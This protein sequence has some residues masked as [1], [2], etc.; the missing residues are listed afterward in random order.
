M[1]VPDMRTREARAAQL[2][3]QRKG[4]GGYKPYG[5]VPIMGQPVWYYY[6]NLPEG[7]LELEVEW[8][9]GDWYWHVTA[10]QMTDKNNEKAPMDE[11]HHSR[12][13]YLVAS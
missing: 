6:Y 10:F 13:R 2:F 5:V 4:Y 7:T 1:I 9:L 11:V 3:M 12:S 8:T